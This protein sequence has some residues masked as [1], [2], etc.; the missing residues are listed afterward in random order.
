MGGEYSKTPDVESHIRMIPFLCSADFTTMHG[1]YLQLE[2]RQA[3]YVAAIPFITCHFNL[4][5]LARS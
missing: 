4:F 1:Q 2:K 3:L 5:I